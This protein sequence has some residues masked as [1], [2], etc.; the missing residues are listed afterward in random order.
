MFTK[1]SG[2][3]TVAVDAVLSNKN[4]TLSEKPSEQA[5]PSTIKTALAT[6]APIPFIDKTS[7]VIVPATEEDAIDMHLEY[8]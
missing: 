8:D 4:Q 1:K 6:G 5:I 2:G 7:V 3:K